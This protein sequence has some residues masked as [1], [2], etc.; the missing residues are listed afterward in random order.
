MTENICK[1]CLLLES[2]KEDIYSSVKEHIEKI[3]PNEKCGD[4]EYK[5]RLAVCSGCDYLS[6]GTCLKCGCYPELRAAFIKQKCP[7]KKW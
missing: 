1:R 7:Y 4:E 5:N 6:G 3:K 2:G